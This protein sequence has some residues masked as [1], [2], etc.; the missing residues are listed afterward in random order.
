RAPPAA[1]AARAPRERDPRARRRSSWRRTCSWPSAQEIRRLARRQQ[2]ATRRRG[3]LE[4][5]AV[6]REPTGERERD[7]VHV[8]TAVPVLGREPWARR[9]A[10]RRH[11]GPPEVAWPLMHRTEAQ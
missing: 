1:P 11:D 5:L 9:P 2:H 10:Q 8:V 3:R 6:E 4:E 7:L